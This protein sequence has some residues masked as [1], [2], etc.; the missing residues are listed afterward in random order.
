VAAEGT[1]LVGPRDVVI[2]GG[3]LIGLG[4]AWRAAGRGLRVEVLDPDPG[5]GASYA[6]AGMLAPVTEAHYNEEALL[7]LNLASSVGY[8]SFVSG[9]EAASGLAVGYRETGTLAVALDGDDLAALEELY[10]FQRSLGLA[11][12]RLGGREARRLEPLLAPG[13]RGALLVT[14]DHQVDNRRLTAALLRAAEGAGVALRRERVT[15]VTVAAGRATGV[16]TDQ[17]TVVAAG[18]VVLAAGCWSGSIEGLPADVVPAVRPVKGQTV[19][20]RVPAAYAP[21]LR[22]NVRGLV[23][24]THV[25]LVPRADGELVIGATQE[26]MGYDTQVTAGGVYELLRDARE[27][28]PAITE[29]PLVETHAG[30]RPGTPDNAPL[31]GPTGL[32]GLVLATGHFRN[33]VL[34]TPVTAEVIAAY[35]TDGVLPDLAR[36]FSADRFS[37]AAGSSLSAPQGLPA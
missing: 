17:G 12:E 36:P 16:R 23:K 19:R 13:A 33:G 10:A 1:D 8:P 2:V 18:Q 28:V 25:Y 20:L 31:L 11:V 14:S 32:P 7:G 6:A 15:A 35:L 30:L 24:G 9:V 29:L 21:F 37:V 22:H 5:R 4:I 27:L 34:L 26:E 3:G